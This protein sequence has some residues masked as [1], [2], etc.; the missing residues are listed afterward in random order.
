MCFEVFLGGLDRLCEYA[1]LMVAGRGCRLVDFRVGLVDAET[2]LK[3]GEAG[4]AS[5][6]CKARGSLTIMQG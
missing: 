4:C 5:P 1:L 3:S 6:G 2:N